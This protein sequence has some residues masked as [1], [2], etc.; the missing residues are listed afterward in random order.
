MTTATAP[1]P[2]TTASSEAFFKPEH[3]ARILDHMNEDHSDANLDYVRHYGA[4]PEAITAKLTDVNQLGI[5]LDATLPS[6][7]IRPVSIAFAEPLSGPG[8]AHTVLVEMAIAAAS[9]LGG[10]APQV[11]GFGGGARHA[12]VPASP[13]TT[14]SLPPPPP[15]A[16]RVSDAFRRAQE[17]AAHLRD[18]FKTIHLSTVSAAG[19]P[20]A[21]VTGAVYA[22]GS[23]LV[24]VSTMSAHTH[25]L[26][27]TGRASVLVVEDEAAA[28]QILARRRLTFACTAAPVP[29]DTPEFTAAM[30]AMKQKFGPIMGQM[31]LMSDFEMVRLTPAKGRLVA[32]FAAAFD[33]NPADWTDLLQHQDTGHTVIRKS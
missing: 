6:G 27:A 20:E 7:E 9:A 22:E 23:F 17:A 5:T 3:L 31:E 19:E 25:N 10:S 29:R 15:A 14:T 2:T 11:P 32:G 33:V 28:K 12:S 18:T 8:D 1:L 21:S 4:L 16:P 24:Y 30:D 26:R 13:A